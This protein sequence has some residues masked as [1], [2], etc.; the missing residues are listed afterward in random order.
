MG[1]A[2]GSPLQFLLL[3]GHSDLDQFIYET[4]SFRVYLRILVDRVVSLPL[5]HNIA[6][7][8]KYL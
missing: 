8:S 6:I 4:L 1:W 2:D 5:A 7:R 3:L